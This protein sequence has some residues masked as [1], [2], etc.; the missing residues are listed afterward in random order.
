MVDS[1]LLQWKAMIRTHK[2]HT[3]PI[4]PV[5]PQVLEHCNGGDLDEILKT[6]GLLSEREARC[7]VIQILRALKYFSDNNLKHIIH[8]DLKPGA[9]DGGCVIS[10]LFGSICSL[11]HRRTSRTHHTLTDTHTH[12]RTHTHTPTHPHTHTYTPLIPCA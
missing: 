2:I 8:Y 10:Q 9:C 5:R 11:T 6:Q 12:T 3:H 4:P 1:I 7:I